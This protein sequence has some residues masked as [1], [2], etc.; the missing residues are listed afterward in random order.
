MKPEHIIELEW[1]SVTA[2]PDF[3]GVP[4]RAGIYVIST[5]QKTDN[6][7]EVKY[8]GQADNLYARAKEHWSKNEKNERLRKHIA[9][10]YLMKFC[11]A[12]VSSQTDRDGLELYLYNLFDPLFNHD[13]PPAETVI[14][15]HHLPMVRKHH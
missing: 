9:E 8:V 7:Y 1:R 14:K 15:C 6:S 4:E 5:L 3:E 10:K 2:P 11:F 12:Q 13:S